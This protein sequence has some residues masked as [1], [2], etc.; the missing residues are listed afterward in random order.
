MPFS[1]NLQDEGEGSQTSPSQNEFQS[2][3]QNEI[4]SKADSY[5]AAWINYSQSGKNNISLLQIK[6][7][8]GVMR[9][10]FTSPLWPGLPP[11]AKHFRLGRAA[12]LSRKAFHA[13]FQWLQ[14]LS[15]L[16]CSSL[17]PKPGTSPAECRNRPSPELPAWLLA[18]RLSGGLV[19]RGITGTGDALACC[20]PRGSALRWATP[21]CS[22]SPCSRAPQGAWGAFR[23]GATQGGECRGGTGPTTSWREL[24]Q[25]A[26]GGDG[27]SLSVPP[28]VT[29]PCTGAMP[30]APGV[31]GAAHVLR[32]C[33][34]IAP[35]WRAQGARWQLK[36][37]LGT[38][39]LVC[40]CASSSPVSTAQGGEDPL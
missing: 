36:P 5:S 3:L 14:V 38:P 15:G 12:C 6:T 28:S 21:H 13:S 2:S 9:F 23:P 8:P 37:H 27:S 22:R 32:Q 7:K 17:L 35:A 30:A 34:Q 31:Q 19:G 39:H 11:L 29:A 1:A 40:P 20:W 10:S 16:L 24:M 33:P 18:P 26:P 4:L 25:A